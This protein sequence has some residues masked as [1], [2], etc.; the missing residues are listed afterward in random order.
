MVLCYDNDMVQNQICEHESKLEFWQSLELEQTTGVE[1]EFCK[2]AKV[3]LAGC[4]DISLL[5][6]SSYGT[7]PTPHYLLRLV[8]FLCLHDEGQ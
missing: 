8:A 3:L 4:Q 1:T 5:L 6:A 7:A 2:Y